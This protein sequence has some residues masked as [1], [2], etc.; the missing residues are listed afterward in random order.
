MA[1]MS[2]FVATLQLFFIQFE[3]QLSI[4]RLKSDSRKLTFK[5]LFIAASFIFCLLVL[6]FSPLFLFL[7]V[8][9]M[10][11]ITAIL[12]QEFNI[13]IGIQHR[14]RKGISASGQVEQEDQ[15]QIIF[16]NTQID[17]LLSTIFRT[18]GKIVICSK[19]TP[20]LTEF[21]LQ[22]AILCN[23]TNIEVCDDM[24]RISHEFR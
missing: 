17:G 1:L 2:S 16:L 11:M 20:I 4:K 22:I 18:S 6:L 24:I 12:G 21:R 8:F 19:L 15:Q 23:S 3:A 9:Y 7:V 13:Q 10:F 5:N 14:L